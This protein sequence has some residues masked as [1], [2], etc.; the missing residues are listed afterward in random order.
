M[1]WGMV[2]M[3]MGCR[4]RRHACRISRRRETEIRFKCCCGR[5]LVRQKRKSGEGRVRGIFVG[6][7]RLLLN[8][9]AMTSL[10]TR[11]EC[12]PRPVRLR[13]RLRLRLLEPHMAG[14]REHVK[15]ILMLA[16]ALEAMAG[17]RMLSPPL[18]LRF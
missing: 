2:A 10:L 3:M 4:W 17:A 15:E 5:R 11:S 7:W 18:E 13:L 14:R 6:G 9:S 16:S 12:L 8:T 1:L